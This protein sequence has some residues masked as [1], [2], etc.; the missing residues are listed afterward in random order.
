MNRFATVSWSAPITSR[1]LL[2]AGLANHAE[3]WHSAYTTQIDTRFI[4]VVEQSSGMGYRGVAGPQTIFSLQ[5]YFQQMN[6]LRAAVSY[7]TGAHAFK[8]GMTDGWASNDRYNSSTNDYG[9][10]YRFNLGV[11]NQITLT[12]TP[13]HTL[14][15]VKADLGIYAQDKWTIHRLTLNLGVR[16]DYFN[17]YFPEN[18]LGPGPN[19]PNRD[20]VLPATDGTNWKDITPRLN[21]AYDLFGN[22]KT[23]VKVSLNKYL[24]GV[25]VTINGAANPLGRLA[26]TVTRTWNDL[27]FP[28]GDPRRGNF[29]PDCDL[30]NPAA[31]G[32]CREM[33]NQNFGKATPTTTLDPAVFNGWNSRGY[34]WEFAASV[35]HQIVPRVSVDVGYFYR[36]YG[37]L[38]V[39]ANRAVTAS[40]FSPFSI[41]APVNPQLPDGGGY[42]ISGLYDLNPNKVGFVDNYQTFASNYGTQLDRWAGADFNINARP[43]RDV[44]LQGGVSTGR[45]LTDNCDV[46]TK[47]GNPSPLY[48]RVVQ[49]LLTQV[50]LI[51]TYTVPKVDVQI[52]ST[53]QSVPG[54]ALTATYNAPAAAVQGLGRALSGGATNVS[55]NLVPPQTMF[56]DRLNQLDLRFGK[57]LKVRRTRSVVGIDV[58][59]ALNANPVLSENS[60]YAV[61]RAPQAILNPRYARLSLQFDF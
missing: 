11:P 42:T 20:L 49:N 18:H 24:T 57:V 30:L 51:G 44:L 48:C 36:T 58:F 59:N 56:G 25:S 21:G 22:G 45:S 39:T 1:V 32:E 2:E 35:Q 4:G 33:S 9:R 52:S 60:N 28:V 47:I 46:V 41:T 6:N 13:Y 23:A 40:D 7:V 3:S 38:I 29:V 8:V 12:A 31:N 17:Q 10:F 26:N 16:Y 61:W 15:N 54:P 43:R 34:N 55:V 14:S 27:L 37:N 5:S 50:K 53:F 19:V